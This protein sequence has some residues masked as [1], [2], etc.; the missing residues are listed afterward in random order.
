MHQDGRPPC[1]THG[2]QSLVT[3]ALVAMLQRRRREDVSAPAKPAI[4]K[5]VIIKILTNRPSVDPMQ[6]AVRSA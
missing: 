1:P 2:M 4:L 5:G 6:Q 3:V